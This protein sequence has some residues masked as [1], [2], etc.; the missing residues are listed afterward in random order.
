MSRQ[1][2]P[3]GALSELTGINHNSIVKWRKQYNSEGITPPLTPG[4]T[5]GFKTS[6]FSAEE[7]DRIEAKLN[8]PKNAIRG[9][10]EL[11]AWLGKE[12]SKEVKYITSVKYTER[13]F[14]SKTKVA[15]K[16]H[17]SKDDGGADALKKLWSKVPGRPAEVR[18]EVYGRKPAFPR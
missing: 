2:Y 15:K 17:V 4:R 1:G 18:L 14:G 11:R 13:N 10:T 8:H 7:Y 6:V 3:K 16:S 9:Y 12:L 5:G